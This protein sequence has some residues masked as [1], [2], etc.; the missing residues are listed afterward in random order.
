MKVILVILVVKMKKRYD[1]NNVRS[2]IG[3]EINKKNFELF[4]LKLISGLIFNFDPNYL[5]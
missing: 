1:N 2:D 5:D 3:F 4:E